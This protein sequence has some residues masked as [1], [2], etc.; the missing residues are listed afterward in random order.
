MSGARFF[1]LAFPMAL[2]MEGQALAQSPTTPR[3]IPLLEN[4]FYV[5]PGGA[6]R[7]VFGY[8]NVTTETVII[9]VGS[10]NFFFPDV[11]ENLGQPRNYLP[12]E[13]HNQFVVT[14]YPGQITG[15]VLMWYLD[16]TFIVV[17]T[18]P[19]GDGLDDCIDNC[20][21]AFNPDQLDSD[22]DGVGDACDQCPNDPARKVPGFCGCGIDDTDSD[23]DGVPDCRDNCPTDATKLDPGM[24]GC[25]MPDTDTDSDG[26]ADCLDPCPN[27][28]NKLDPGFCGCGTPELDENRDR[29]PDCLQRTNGPAPTALSMNNAMIIPPCAASAHMGI[30]A[31][32]FSPVLVFG[33]FRAG[34]RQ[35]F[36]WR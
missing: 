24:C 6:V 13:H 33:R 1:M 9:G 23:A 27:D 10:N 30:L 34:R 29:I 35:P 8:H 15:R 18:N 11:D 28:P 12:G 5:C 26:V 2:L 19:D 4:V 7:A 25:G 31:G 3:V 14:Y 32:L 17:S 36:R 21:A 22:F 16:G 20:P